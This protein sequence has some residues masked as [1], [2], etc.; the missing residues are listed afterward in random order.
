MELAVSYYIP[1][2]QPDDT[3]PHTYTHVHKKIFSLEMHSMT[4][5]SAPLLTLQVSA[6]D[7]DCG[8][9]ES[10][11]YSLVSPSAAAE[12]SMRAS[13]GQL[14]VSSALDYERK[15]IYEFEVAATDQGDTLLSISLKCIMFFFFRHVFWKIENKKMD[16]SSLTKVRFYLLTQDIYFWFF[17]AYVF[18][19]N[20]WIKGCNYD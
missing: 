17:S 7:L 15:Q 3:N 2:L 1:S 9:S 18:D 10:I 14:C 8:Q 16:F 4:I 20:F 12:L 6:T 13:S 5:C 19:N 11:T